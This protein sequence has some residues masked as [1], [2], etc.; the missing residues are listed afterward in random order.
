MTSD[1][2]ERRGRSP[3]PGAAAATSR[4][5]DGPVH[6]VDFG[7]N[8]PTFRRSCSSTAWRLAPQLGARGSRAS[9]NRRAVAVDLHG[10]G[11][12][13]GT[14][15]NATVHENQRAARPFHP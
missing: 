3:L 13:A 9:A 1:E 8:L 7:T 10:F 6:W 2:R 15:R 4:D 5:L 12:T 11:M 14:Q